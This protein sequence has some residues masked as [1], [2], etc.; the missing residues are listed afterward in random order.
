LR[1]GWTTR[2]WSVRLAMQNQD[3]TLGDVSQTWHDISS[4]ESTGTH[5]SG[6]S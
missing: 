1:Q 6:N 4:S 2:Q 3:K 5:S